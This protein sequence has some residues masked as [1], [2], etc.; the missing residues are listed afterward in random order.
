MMKKKK[1]LFQMWDVPVL[2]SAITL[3][4][5]GVSGFDQNIYV[6]LICIFLG[7]G[8]FFYFAK[9]VDLRVK[10]NQYQKSVLTAEIKATE[11]IADDEK[12]LYR[13]IKQNELEIFIEQELKAFYP[14]AFVMRNVYCPTA[15]GSTVQI[16]VLMISQDGIFLI[17]AKNLNG[18][19]V[20]DWEND[21]TLQVVYPG[22]KS[23]PLPNPI[24]QNHIHYKCLKNL[25]SINTA[26]VFKSII[27]LGDLTTYELKTAPHYVSICQRTG[28]HKSIRY[29]SNK[30]KGILSENKVKSIMEAIKNEMAHT[31]KRES[32]HRQR[33]EANR[34]PSD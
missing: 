32:T 5:T 11:A 3:L 13:L 6:F 29:R 12:N 17:E 18:Q 21:D 2:L 31:P 4:I 10:I 15:S 1:A 26:G 27:V 19:I 20:G 8:L 28:L 25:L 30:S 34:N 24:K 14:D 7:M 23:Y 16:D 33:I 9:M 22:G